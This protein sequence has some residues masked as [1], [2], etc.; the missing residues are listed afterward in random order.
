M[1]MLEFCGIVEVTLWVCHQTY[2]GSGPG[3]CWFILNRAIG[4]QSWAPLDSEVAAKNSNNYGFWMFMD[5][6]GAYHYGYW[7]L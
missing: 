4:L 5:V 6:N 3:S 2:P 7:G 1:M